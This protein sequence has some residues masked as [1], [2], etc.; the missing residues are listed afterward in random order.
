MTVIKHAGDENKLEFGQMCAS[1]L[2]FLGTF[3]QRQ[4]LHTVLS[5]SPFQRW[6]GGNEGCQPS[7]SFTNPQQY[8]PCFR[9]E[10]AD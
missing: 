9:S 5:R 3:L 8:Q 2:I 10:D 4:S 7:F 1:T 6:R